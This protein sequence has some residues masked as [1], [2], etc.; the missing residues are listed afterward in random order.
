MGG[1][2]CEGVSA[3]E[4]LSQYQQGY[5]TMVDGH[6]IAWRVIGVREVNSCNSS[7]D[8]VNLYTAFPQTIARYFE[9]SAYSF[10]DN[11]YILFA[12]QYR[13]LALYCGYRSNTI[14]Y[15]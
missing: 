1:A 13:C 5:Y 7:H 10:D 15:P 14:V 4:Y 2:G 6:G 3:R 11:A 9:Y 12:P 8:E